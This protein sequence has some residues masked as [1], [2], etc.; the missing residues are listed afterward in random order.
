MFCDPDENNNNLFH[1]NK[2]CFMFVTAI[3]AYVGYLYTYCFAI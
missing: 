2:Y 1:I 3:I